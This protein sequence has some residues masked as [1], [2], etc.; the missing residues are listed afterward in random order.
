MVPPSAECPPL[1]PYDAGGVPKST[2]PRGPPYNPRATAS[3]QGRD[4]REEGDHGAS[5]PT[6]AVVLR[7][8]ARGRGRAEGRRY[9]VRRD[10]R[11]VRGALGPALSWSADRRR[12]ADRLHP[13]LRPAGDDDPHDQL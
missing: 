10:R 8:R 11:G 5:D 6:A 4:P 3:R 1:T 2:V 7:R 9:A 12:G 13:P